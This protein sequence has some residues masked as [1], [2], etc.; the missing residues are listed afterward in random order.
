MQD[1][2]RLIAIS[3][4]VA[5]TSFAAGAVPVSEV[6]GPAEPPPEGYAERQYVDS[7][8][9]M[10]VRVEG[11]DGVVAWAPVATTEGELLC[12]HKPTATLNLSVDAPP[13]PSVEPVPEPQVSDETPPAAAMA[14]VEE[15]AD[16]PETVAEPEPVANPAPTRGTTGPVRLLAISTLPIA[17]T[18]C[19]NGAALVERY[20]LSD[21]RQPVRCAGPADDPLDVLVNRGFLRAVK[22]APAVPAGARY[23]QL[24]AFGQSANVDQCADLA[25][26]LGFPAEQRRV[27]GS[28]L[29]LVLAGPFDRP[30]DLRAAWLAFQTAGYADAF[31]R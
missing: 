11:D 5:M 12:G 28:K 3:V 17:Q 20:L 7:D 4:A 8:G 23:L 1:K 15:P 26:R 24:G 10:F 22:R 30:D 21:G 31:Y 13:P 25:K 18:D 9:C 2:V 6:S 19:K 14:D 16:E 27:S 29:T